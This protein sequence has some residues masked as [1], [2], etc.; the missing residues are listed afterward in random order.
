MCRIFSR[1]ST[2]IFA[3]V[4]LLLGIST[5]S[6]GAEKLRVVVLT[7]IAGDPDDQQSLI[8]FLLYANE[9]DVEGLVATTSCWKYEHPNVG[10]V[11]G[12]IDAYEKVYPNLISHDSNYPP[13]G[14]LR[15][16]AKQGVDAYGMA[17]AV[18]Q[19][20]NEADTTIHAILTLSDNGTPKLTRYRRVVISVSAT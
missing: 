6:V 16:V 15:N 2:I 3:M 14:Q 17:A 11:H 4:F 20:D 18:E 9:F 12:V 19:M 13:P 10:A 7:D 8:R 1:L 5:G